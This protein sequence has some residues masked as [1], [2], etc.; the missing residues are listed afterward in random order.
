[1][2]KTIVRVPSIGI[3]FDASVVS[4]IDV[5]YEDPPLTCDSFKVMPWRETTNIIFT[6]GA[7]LRLH[8]GEGAWQIIKTVDFVLGATYIVK[9]GDEE[10]AAVCVNDPDD[11]RFL[12]PIVFDASK[13]VIMQDDDARFEYEYEEFLPDEKVSELL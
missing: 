2:I 3:E 9:S 6:N 1:M 8:R 4:R 13:S 11:K 12:T 10:W 7:S 5:D